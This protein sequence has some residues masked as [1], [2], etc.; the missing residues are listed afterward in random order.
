M[1]KRCLAGG[2]MRSSEARSL[3]RSRYINRIEG[4]KDYETDVWEGIP[5]VEIVKYARE[6][7]A[8]LIVMSHHTR[9]IDP[10][11]AMLGTTMEQVVLRSN[12]PVISV[13]HPDKI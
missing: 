13:N 10:E 5:Y 6:K 7:F 9:K 4:I 3:I 11:A 1:G 12:C 2:D 8:D